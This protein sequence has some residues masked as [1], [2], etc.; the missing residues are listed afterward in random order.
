MDLL[1]LEDNDIDATIFKG[2]AARCRRI[3]S[4]EASNPCENSRRPWPADVPDLICADHLLPDR[5][6]RDALSLGNTLSPESPFIVITGAGEEDVAVEYMKQGAADY[7]SKRRLDQFPLALDITYSRPSATVPSATC[8]AKKRPRRLN[9]ELLA[10]I[11]HVEGERDEEKRS[12]SRDIHDQ[13]G[14]ELTAIKLGMFWI[15]RQLGEGHRHRGRPQA[16]L[17]ELV[18]LNTE[19]I[20]QVRDIA[21]ALRPV[22]LDQVGLSAGIETLGPGLQQA[23]DPLWRSTSTRPARPRIDGIQCGRLFRIVQ[24]ALTNIATPRFR[25]ASP[26][27]VCCPE[28]HTLASRSETMARACRT[29]RQTSNRLHGLGMVGMRERVRNHDGSSTSVPARG[30]HHH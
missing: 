17:E 28:G 19:V 24:E 26:M 6:G 7:L 23:K 2:A 30:R 14:Q 22:V 3:W 4:F 8:R 5:P 13:L 20:Q 11:R 18:D 29:D 21:R 1:H 25:R 9:G 16:K 15:D 12:L 27:S 10:L